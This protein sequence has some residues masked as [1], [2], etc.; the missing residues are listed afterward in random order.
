MQRSEIRTKTHSQVSSCALAHLLADPLVGKIKFESTARPNKLEWVEYPPSVFHSHKSGI[1]SSP[2]SP[3]LLKGSKLGRIVTTKATGSFFNN[4]LFGDGLLL[5]F[6]VLF[7]HRCHQRSWRCA[8]NPSALRLLA[9]ASGAQ[10]DWGQRRREG[11][12]GSGPLVQK[13]S[14]G[15]WKSRKTITLGAVLLRTRSVSEI[16]FLF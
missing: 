4:D 9:C 13:K 1:F 5:L 7:G 6:P 8:P 12:R 10:G 3:V 2:F 15:G 16:R 14:T 11:S